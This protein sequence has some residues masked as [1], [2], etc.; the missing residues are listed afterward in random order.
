MKSLNSYLHTNNIDTYLSANEILECQNYHK[1]IKNGDNV[2]EEVTLLSMSFSVA[3]STPV[4]LQLA[5]MLMLAAG[6]KFG[7]KEKNALKQIGHHLDH[8]G[9]KVHHKYIAAITYSL[10]PIL[11]KLPHKWQERIS[12][13]IFMLII[14]LKVVS[15]GGVASIEAVLHKKSAIKYIIYDILNTIKVG[16]ITDYLKTTF[17]KGILKIKRYFAINLD[18]GGM[19]V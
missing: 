16:E 3:L 7:K 2:D 19:N 9:H 14:L 12:Q 17:K 18:L 4:I 8:I 13:L 5:G 11:G 15:S 1:T 6:H 10:K